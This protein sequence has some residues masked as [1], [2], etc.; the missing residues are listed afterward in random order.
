MK[1]YH[2]SLSLPADALLRLYRGQVRT[3]RVRCVE[4]LVIE[5]AADKLRPFVSPSG[6][7]GQFV[8][9]TDDQHRFISLSRW[10]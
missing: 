4:G 3:L 5:L 10:G 7:H 2:F 9:S 1:Q 6:V 8:L